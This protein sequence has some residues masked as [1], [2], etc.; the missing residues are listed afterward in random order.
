MRV[1]IVEDSPRDA[2]ALLACL[3]AY[4]RQHGVE[5]EAERFP[6]GQAFLDRG[7]TERWDLLLLD[8]EMPELSGI[9]TARAIREENEELIIIFVTSH[10]QYALDAFD[11]MA[12]DYIV[13]PVN[14]EAFA[15]KLDRACR[16]LEKSREK[17][18]LVTNSEGTH[19][20]ACRRIRF[21]EVQDH[22]VTYHTGEG[23]IRAVGG[24]TLRALEAELGAWHFARCS[25]CYMVN[26]LHVADVRRDQVTVG[27]HTLKISRN[28]KRPFLQ[29]LLEYWGD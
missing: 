4:Q 25:K 11:V 24:S 15:L 14:P 13:K 2:E 5:V 23:T 29:K 18:L 12:L 28:Y 21:I 17:T 26:L 3:R 6:S 20:L 10:A 27:G 22:A 8:V 19:R 16:R 9:Q 1:A 7:R